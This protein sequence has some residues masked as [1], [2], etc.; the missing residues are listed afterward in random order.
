MKWDIKWFENEFYVS[1]VSFDLW[2]KYEEV[3][4][5]RIYCKLN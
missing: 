1:I 4:L 3:Y 2:L 5:L